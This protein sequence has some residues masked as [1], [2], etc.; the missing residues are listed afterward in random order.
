[1]SATISSTRWLNFTE[2]FANLNS[3]EGRNEGMAASCFPDV[4]VNLT[5]YHHPARNQESYFE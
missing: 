5:S 3:T 2:S 1:M 4:Q